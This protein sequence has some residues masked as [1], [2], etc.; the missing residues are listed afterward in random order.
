[1]ADV[2]RPRA[3][4]DGASGSSDAG[5]R[6]P[7]RHASKAALRQQR[8]RERKRNATGITPD[9][10]SSPPSPESVTA[11]KAAI[12]AL[13]EHLEHVTPQQLVES[14]DSIEILGV[15]SDCELCSAWLGAVATLAGAV[16]RR[17]GR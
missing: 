16:M 5:R 7:S 10:S 8:Y 17:A 4:G 12:D 13:V 15:S 9:A 3:G 11:I 2:M 6:S 14:C 1:M